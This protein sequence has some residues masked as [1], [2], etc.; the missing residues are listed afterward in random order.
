MSTSKTPFSALSR[1]RVFEYVQ[2]RFVDRQT[3]A[4]GLRFIFV[5]NF[6][7]IEYKF[8]YRKSVCDL[9]L[10]SF[11]MLCDD[12]AL[13]APS[14]VKAMHFTLSQRFQVIEALKKKAEDLAAGARII[15]RNVKMS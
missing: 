9:V 14:V 4:G 12:V 15:G 1:N 6:V 13:Q 7:K 3:T 11:Q 5:R 10:E 2:G 8:N